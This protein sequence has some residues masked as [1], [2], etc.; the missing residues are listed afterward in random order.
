M[1]ARVSSP[2]STEATRIWR[3]S[4]GEQDD[5]TEHGQEGARTTAFGSAWRV[6][7][8]RFEQ[9][10]F[11]AAGGG[12][13]VWAEETGLGL[14]FGVAPVS[15]LRATRERGWFCARTRINV[16]PLVSNKDDLKGYRLGETIEL[17]LSLVPASF[18]SATRAVSSPRRDKPLPCPLP[19]PLTVVDRCW[20]VKP[21]AADGGSE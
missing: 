9:Q 2:P 20:C 11:A 6:A 7:C 18:P 16:F 1:A 3:S 4:S 21:R 12:G 10:A 8:T 14:G 5:Y 17:H 19:F 15:P 13:E